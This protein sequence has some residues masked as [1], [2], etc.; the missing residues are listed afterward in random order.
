METY[1]LLILL[2]VVAHVAKLREQ[3]RRVAL[4][5]GY[6]GQFRIEQLMETLA[7]GYLRA[8][9]E[10][11]SERQAQIWGLMDASESELSEQFA[12]F[13]DDVARAEPGTLQ[14]SKSSWHFPLAE[15]LFPTRSFDLRE[16]F[17]IHARGIASVVRN[18]DGLDRKQKAFT[19]SAELYL[20]QHTCHWYCKSKAVASARL[21]AR[22]QTSHAQVV[23][24]VSSETRQAYLALTA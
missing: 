22:H 20:M 10:E 12:R 11:D 21:L 6:L 16:A 13:A 3:Q 8:L 14:V 1:A 2:I 9:G 17:R 23:A 5:A 7:D 18:E 24:A 19:L 15:R 4:L